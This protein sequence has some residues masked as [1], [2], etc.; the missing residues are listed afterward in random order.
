M[1]ISRTVI[2]KVVEMQWM[3]PGTFTCRLDKMPVGRAALATW[4][5]RGVVQDITSIPDTKD[6]VVI[7]VHSLGTD[8]LSTAPDEVHV[9][10]IHSALIERMVVYTPTPEEKAT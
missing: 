9:S 3:D 4:L 6:D 5:E 10:A 2:G 1:K 8:A 7:L